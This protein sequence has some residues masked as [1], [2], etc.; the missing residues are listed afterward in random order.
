[1]ITP[2]L[3]RDYRQNNRME[4]YKCKNCGYVSYPEKRRVCP[5]CKK[6]PS[7]FETIT[8]GPRGKILTYTIAYTLPAEFEPPIPLAIVEM[9]GG[10]RIYAMVSECKPEQI[11]IGMEVELDYREIFQ[12]DG[13]HVQSFKVK[14]VKKEKNQNEK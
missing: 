9:D 2:P 8:L 5:K 14:P 1:M 3:W 6:A 12:E 11:K 10:G 13:Y 7:E 4:A